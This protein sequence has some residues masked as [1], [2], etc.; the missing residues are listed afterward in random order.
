MSCSNLF[1]ICVGAILIGDPLWHIRRLLDKYRHRAAQ[2]KQEKDFAMISYIMQVILN[3]LGH[4]DDSVH[5]SGEVCIEE[6]VMRMF[7]VSG[8]VTAARS[9][10]LFKCFLAVYLGEYNI[11]QKVSLEIQD[12]SSEGINALFIPQMIFL[13]AIADVAS[14]KSSYWQSLQAGRTLLKKLKSF[15]NLCPE[16]VLNK[17]YL[18]EAERCAIHGQQDRA[19]SKFQ[20]SI[21]YARDQGLIQEQALASE[22][23]GIRLLEW[24]K[25]DVALEYLGEARNL[26]RRWGSTFKADRITASYF[27]YTT[28]GG[29]ENKT[30]R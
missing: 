3:L 18:I 22:R 21:N 1:L 29:V 8:N 4:E 23:A 15:S 2:L 16:N 14:E 26:Y 7:E 17:V 13:G 9:L 10:K 19:T 24:G 27:R 5:V 30:A 12:L 28:S 20:K 6:E 11:A 25:K